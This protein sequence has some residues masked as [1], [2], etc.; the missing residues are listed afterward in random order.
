MSSFNGY[1]SFGITTLKVAKFSNLIMKKWKKNHSTTDFSLCYHRKTPI[2]KLNQWLPN[3]TTL[4]RRSPEMVFGCNFH[5]RHAEK[6]FLCYLSCDLQ[7]KK[8]NILVKGFWIMQLYIVGHRNI[9][10]LIHQEIYEILL[11]EISSFFS[12]FLGRGKLSFQ[13]FV[14]KTVLTMV[15]K[16]TEVQNGV[17]REKIDLRPRFSW[18]ANKIPFFVSLDFCLRLLSSSICNLDFVCALSCEGLKTARIVSQLNMMWQWDPNLLKMY[19]TNWR[20]QELFSTF[21]DELDRHCFYFYH[22]DEGIMYKD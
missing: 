5:L 19:L 2:G 3:S 7:K 15:H 22:W 21:W 4:S 6:P 1:F 12:S 9:R 20:L 8:M 17:K 10:I 16:T 14:I 18:C 11:L 13:H